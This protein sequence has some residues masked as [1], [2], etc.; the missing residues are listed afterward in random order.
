MHHRTPVILAS[1]VIG[2][3]AA[4]HAQ[5]QSAPDEASTPGVSAPADQQAHDTAA[6]KS[7]DTVLAGPLTDVQSAVVMLRGQVVY[8]F[9]RDGNPDTLHPTQSVAK[10]ALSALVGIAL[11]QGH[12]Q[13]LD[14][15]VVALVPAWASA[16][17]DPRAATISVR[18]LLTM[19]AGFA[20]N[21]PTGTAP[22]MRPQEAWARPLA[23]APGQVFAY[24]NS[25][26]NLLWAVLEKAAGMPLA[27][28]ARQHLVQPLAMAEPAYQRGLQ[29]R[30]LDMAKL[31]QLYLQK[32][33]WEGR[34]ILPEA[35]VEASTQPQNAGGPPVG[36]SY[37]YMW[38]VSSTK[39]PRPTFM[40]S[41]YSGQFI[42]VHPAL[43]LVIAT[44][45]HVSPEVQKRGHALQ[46]IRRHLF[47]A[48]HQR[49]A[50]DKR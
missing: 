29:L 48:A 16:H 13:S 22:G 38:W 42:W 7:I 21:D 6:F 24:D 23:H 1:L 32:G 4:A 49:L 44:T 35:F 36:L 46:L 18:H 9:H 20:V 45:S 10:S 2:I 43:D 39:A 3:A 31:G 14:Q 8:S 50:S 33:V 47:A 17:S 27:D 12:I 5:P 37:G 15:P 19:T 41:G 25:V 34:Q 40:A 30:T 28:Y 26:V 11:A